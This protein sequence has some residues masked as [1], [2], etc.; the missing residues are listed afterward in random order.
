MKL[1]ASFWLLTL[2]DSMQE[3]NSQSCPL[4]CI[5]LKHSMIKYLKKLL[6]DKTHSKI[7]I[8]SIY[9]YSVSCIT[10]S[11]LNPS[12]LC[13][14]YRLRSAQA[15]SVLLFFHVSSACLTISKMVQRFLAIHIELYLIIVLISLA[16]KLRCV[17]QE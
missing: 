12:L 4:L 9:L 17:N 6:K 5:Y 13:G 11:E 8:L 16:R 3:I 2:G 10:K 14:Y 15:G 1:A 7:L